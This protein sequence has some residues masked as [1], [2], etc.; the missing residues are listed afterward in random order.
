M[1]RHLVMFKLAAED[2]GQRR[3]DIEQIR[4]RLKALSDL[5]GV[6][7]IEV[8]PDLGVVS[9]HW[10]VVLVADYA[11]V[12][13]LDAYQAHP[14]HSEVVTWINGVVT[15]RAIVDFQMV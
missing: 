9:N 11:S 5:E 8:Y 3:V 7:S 10:D 12:E 15:D 1:I 4:S 13:A 2:P 14:R 6:L